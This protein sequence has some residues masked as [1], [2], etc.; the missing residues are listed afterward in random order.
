MASECSGR[1]EEDKAISNIENK[2]SAAQNAIHTSDL[3]H[4]FHQYTNQG[5]PVS[6]KL[7]YSLFM[8]ST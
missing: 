5:I 8:V 4:N 6:W 1:I 3:I 7:F 2:I